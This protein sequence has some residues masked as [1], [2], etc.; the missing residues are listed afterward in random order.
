[1]AKKKKKVANAPAKRKPPQKV[2]TDFMSAFTSRFIHD[3]ATKTW[4]WPA[5]GRAPADIVAEFET[6]VNVLMQSEVAI[7]PVPSDGSDSLES[8][9]AIFL[10]AEKWPVSTVIPKKW[11]GEQRTVRLVEIAVIV[12]RLLHAIDVHRKIA[13]G[14]SPEGWPPH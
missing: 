2:R 10:M 13:A 6:F 5:A 11:R 4:L 7:Q 9:L 1:M 8:Q 14:G 3:S 12:E